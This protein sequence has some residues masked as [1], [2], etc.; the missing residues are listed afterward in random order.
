MLSVMV[1]SGVMYWIHLNRAVREDGL[2]HAV[3]RHVAK[4]NTDSNGAIRGEALGWVENAQDRCEQSFSKRQAHCILK[5]DSMALV[6]AC[7]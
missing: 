6:Q 2:C 7:N 4:L 5:A 3:G 1:A